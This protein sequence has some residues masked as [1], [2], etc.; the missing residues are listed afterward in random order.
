MQVYDTARSVPQTALKAINGGRLKGKSD[1]NPVWRI[2]RMTEIF[3]PCGIGWKYTITRQWVETYGQEAKAFCNIDLFIKWNGEWS[4]AIPGTGGASIVEVGRETYVN[5]EAY[6]MALTDALSVAMKSLGIAADIYFAADAGQPS[7]VN[8]GTKYET[9][10][11]AAPATKA[12]APAPQP[13]PQ[14][15]TAEQTLMTDASS[16]IAAAT[17]LDQLK[18]IYAAFP[19]LQQN[20]TFIG[21]LSSR[22]KSLAA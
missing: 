9:P 11:Q 10:A 5:D 21:M 3:G 1:I 15:M 17:T 20:H 2:K 12:A 22:K 18:E 19:S 8:F 14:P 7:T 13:K 16:R 4:D 6:K